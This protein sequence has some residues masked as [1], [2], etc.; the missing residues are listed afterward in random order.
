MQ[1]IRQTL[2]RQSDGNKQSSLIEKSARVNSENSIFR[3]PTIICEIEN[4]M[5]VDGWLQNDS[6]KQ[7]CEYSDLMR[8][9]GV[10]ESTGESNRP[11]DICLAKGPNLQRAVD[12]SCE[13]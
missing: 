4:M 8:V 6:M 12:G 1:E 11:V 13:N 2:I 5:K 9:D 3:K 10:T 7:D